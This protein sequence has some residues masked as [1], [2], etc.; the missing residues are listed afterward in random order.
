[1]PNGRLTPRRMALALLAPLVALAGL[2]PAG[3]GEKA[4]VPEILAALKGHTDAVYAVAFSKDGQYPVTGGFDHTPKL[5][6]T[7]TGKELKTFDGPAGRQKLEL[8][9]AF[10]PD[11]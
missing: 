2:M 3:G 10:S 11:G 8:T 4:K 1:M 9:A 7:A 5:W 6:E